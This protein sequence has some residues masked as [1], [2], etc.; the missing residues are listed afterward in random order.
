MKHLFVRQASLYLTP[1]I[2][3]AC[4]LFQTCGEKK[5]ELRSID[6]TKYVDTISVKSELAELREI[7]ISKTFSGTLEGEEQANIISKIPERIMEIKIKVGDYVNKGKLLFVLDKGGASSQYYQSQ[8]VYLN[9]EKNLERMKNLFNEGAVSRQSL[10]AAQTAYDVAKA[11]FEAAKSTVEITSPLSGVITSLNVNIGDLAN[12]QLVMA[13][14]AKI[15]L[16]KARFNT[17]ESDIADIFIGQT[18]KVF[19]ELNPELI[20]AAK[21][22]QISKAADIQ[23]RTFEV[24]ALFSNT[25]DKWF[26][27]G[28]FCRVQVNVK[29]QKDALVIPMTSIVKY[30]NA[31]GVFVIEGGRANFKTITTGM[32]DGNYIEVHSGLSAGEIIVTLGMNN[33]KNGTVVVESNK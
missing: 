21:V 17:G 30:D 18:A 25:K 3:I 32:T 22:I 2:I 33:L 9:S 31:S 15:S 13:T 26:K 29:T 14:V 23:S 5:Q 12:P 8:A 7:N 27:P 11:N 28:M 16:L 20:Q 1:A 4:F 24:Q 6:K 10:D 19:S